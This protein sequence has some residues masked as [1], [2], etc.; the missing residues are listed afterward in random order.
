VRA[1]EPDYACCGESLDPASLLAALTADP[2]ATDILP[3]IGTRSPH[4]L[5]PAPVYATRAQ[6]ERMRAIVRAVEAV[7]ALPAYRER[8]LAKAPAIARHDPG[9]ARGGLLGFDFHLRDEEIALIEINTN[10]GGL[11][12]NVLLA[13]GQRACCE[14]VRDMLP[15]A[16]AIT[17]RGRRI[18]GMFREEWR[19]AGVPRPLRHVVI[20]DEDPPAQFLYPEFVLFQRLLQ[21]AGLRVS[22]ANPAALRLE[23]GVLWHAEERV[24]LVYNR[25]TDFML[26]RPASA[27]LRAAHLAGAALLS[28]HPRAHALYADKRNLALLGSEAA[29]VEI[30]VPA[31]LRDLLHSGI[32]ATQVVQAGNAA[33]LWTQRRRLFFKPATG[34]GSRAVYRGDKLTRRVWQQILAGEYVAQ[35]FAPAGE[36]IV[37]TPGAPAVL[38]FDVRNY[39]YGGEVL[40]VAARLYQGQATNMR[41]PGGGF[42]PVYTR[43]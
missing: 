19:L 25:L 39:A 13:R 4:V 20:V 22:I 34:Y 23:N 42:A 10:P 11:M 40:W 29:L 21:R 43:G 14:A 12:L 28:P 26:E 7:V 24:D 37:A 30:G 36:R 6:L 9:G 18:A 41:T 5:S 3:L 8:V 15:D 27:V 16:A 31:E 38:K 33:A 35:A 1:G 32:P 17:A 2:D